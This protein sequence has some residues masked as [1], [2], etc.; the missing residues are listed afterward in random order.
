LN[1]GCEACEQ[2]LKA[3]ISDKDED[4]MT[5]EEKKVLSGEKEMPRAYGPLSNWEGSYCEFCHGIGQFGSFSIG[6]MILLTGMILNLPFAYLFGISLFTMIGMSIVVGYYGRFPILGAIFGPIVERIAALHFG[7][8]LTE[9]AKRKYGSRVE[10]ANFE[11]FAE[12]DRRTMDGPEM[13]IIA[14]DWAVD[15][16]ADI[17]VNGALMVVE[18]ENGQIFDQIAFHPNMF[19]NRFRNINDH[20]GVTR[21]NVK[22]ICQYSKKPTTY[23]EFIEST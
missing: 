13:H 1:M 3:E 9:A 14:S 5:E 16:C 19:F 21:E 11:H 4:E 2:N 12:L 8:Y 7:V 20:V 17:D 15:A 6:M 23:S 22:N 18:I 10:N